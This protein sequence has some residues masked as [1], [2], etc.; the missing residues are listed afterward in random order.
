MY[1]HSRYKLHKTRHVLRYKCGTASDSLTHSVMVWCRW[2]WAYRTRGGKNDTIYIYTIY[3]YEGRYRIPE[4]QVLFFQVQP[5][6]VSR[7]QSVS[8]YS[9]ILPPHTGT[10][11]IRDS[12]HL[13]WIPKSLPI[14][15]SNCYARSACRISRN[16]WTKRNE[17]YV[18]E[19]TLVTFFCKNWFLDAQNIEQRCIQKKSFQQ[20]LNNFG[21]FGPKYWSRRYIFEESELRFVITKPK[22]S[23]SVHLFSKSR[24]LDSIC[25]IQKLLNWSNLKSDMKKSAKI[26]TKFVKIWSLVL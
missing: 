23:E 16:V 7:T 8:F 3:I 21:D 18:S 13:D 6:S 25:S 22:T 5:L 12:Q 14:F 10:H 26:E 11:T 20:L 2:W 1:T 4:K 15:L 17:I 9:I 19:E 24:H